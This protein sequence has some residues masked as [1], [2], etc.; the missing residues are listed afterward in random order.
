MTKGRGNEITIRY[1]NCCLGTKRI[2]LRFGMQGRF[3]KNDHLGSDGEVKKS[4]PLYRQS[5]KKLKIA[6]PDYEEGTFYKI[7]TLDRSGHIGSLMVQRNEQLDN[8]LDPDKDLWLQFNKIGFTTAMQ[9]DIY[10]DNTFQIRLHWDT[11]FYE[12]TFG[13]CK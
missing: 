11:W 4:S 6:F 5:L 7:E 3:F 2:R 13:T 8:L 1:S 9:I 10:K 12:N